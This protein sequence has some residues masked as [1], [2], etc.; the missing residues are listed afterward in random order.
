M[1]RT[2]KLL[3]HLHE[4]RGIQNIQNYYFLNDV[5]SVPSPDRKIPTKK[6]DGVIRVYPNPQ[7]AAHTQSKNVDIA[8]F[9]LLDTS[10]LH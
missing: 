8:A 3:E 7:V 5:E 10:V 2:L 9:G 4:Y 1:Y 6:E